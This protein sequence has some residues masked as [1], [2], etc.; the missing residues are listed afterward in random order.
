MSHVLSTNLALIHPRLFTTLLL[1][2]P[3]IQL[4]PPALG[5]GT[6]PPGGVN[7][8]VHKD[9]FFPSRDDAAKFVSKS[10]MFKKFDPRVVQL[11]IQYGFRDLPTAL[12]PDVESAEPATSKAVTYTTSKHQESLIQIRENFNARDKQGRVKINRRTHA[13]M[14]PLAAFIP[15]YRPE[16]RS[17][18]LRLPTLRPSVLFL[19]GKQTFLSLDEMREGIKMTGSGVG[20]SGGIPEGRVKEDM[21]LKHGHVS[22][23]SCPFC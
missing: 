12:Y 21:M 19:L 14:D 10:P 18:F 22:L 16:P 15:L 8:T 6:D 7:Y 1:L 23:P 20:G 13:D 2:D 4:S 17:T 5:F 9:D 3:V 11:M